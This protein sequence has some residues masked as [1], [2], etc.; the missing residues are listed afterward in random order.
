MWFLTEKCSERPLADKGAFCKITYGFSSLTL[1]RTVRLTVKYDCKV[2]KH[3]MNSKVLGFGAWYMCTRMRSTVGSFKINRVLTV[4]SVKWVLYCTER[5]IVLC[6]FA[7]RAGRKGW[8]GYNSCTLIVEYS[9]VSC[10]VPRHLVYLCHSFNGIVASNIDIANFS[11]FYHT[12]GVSLEGADADRQV[13]IIESRRDC[14]KRGVNG[15]RGGQ[16]LQLLHDGQDG[17][18]GERAGLT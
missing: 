15:E 10:L 13:E 9:C 7:I 16:R 12:W 11:T 4:Y 6:I 8:T 1:R 3:H 5:W 14:I 17:E 18:R 2:M